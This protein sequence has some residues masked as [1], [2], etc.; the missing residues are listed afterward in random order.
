MNQ[1]KARIVLDVTPEFKG[2]I[3]TKAKENNQSVSGYLTMLVVQ[4]LSATQIDTYAET[5]QREILS[6]VLVNIKTVMNH[7]IFQNRADDIMKTNL[8]DAREVLQSYVNW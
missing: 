3:Q 8:N 1:E 4:D 6:G 7:P 2:Q 5:H